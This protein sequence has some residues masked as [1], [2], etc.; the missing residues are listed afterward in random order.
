MALYE[1]TGYRGAINTEIINIIPSGDL[2]N[3]VV[4]TNDFFDFM[5]NGVSKVEVKVEGQVI[6]TDDAGSR[7]VVIN[8]TD[9][10]V[11]F[12]DF[13]LAAGIYIDVEVSIYISGST[14]RIVIAGPS[15]ATQVRLTF[16]T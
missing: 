16:H 9:L 5:L 7:S 2:T 15:L 14:E 4:D 8:G 13:D 6:S 1:A 10:E 12:G 11:E 3:V